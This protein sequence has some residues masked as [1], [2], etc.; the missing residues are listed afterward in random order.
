MLSPNQ[1]CDLI[2]ETNLMNKLPTNCSN[3]SSTLVSSIESRTPTSSYLI[4]KQSSALTTPTIQSVTPQFLN[5]FRQIP[6]SPISFKADSELLGQLSGDEL[7]YRI[8]S[9]EAKNRKLLFENGCLIK[10]IN[11]NLA[12]IQLIRHQMLE[13]KKDNSELRDLCCYLD[14]ERTRA[15]EIARE[16]ELFGDHISKVLKKEITNYNKKL[17]QLESKQFELVK[18]NYELK[19]LCLLLDK[20][21]MNKTN[22]KHQDDRSDLTDEYKSS[23][24]ESKRRPFVNQKILNYIKLLESELEQSE[25]NRQEL[26]NELKSSNDQKLSNDELNNKFSCTSKVK[27]LKDSRPDE[28]NKAFEIL[29]IEQSLD[30]ENLQTNSNE[31][32]NEDKSNEVVNDSND[33]ISE[34]QRVIIKQLCSAAYDKM[35]F[36]EEDDQ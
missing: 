33:M 21:T 27:E 11:S 28:L 20:A 23:T 9:L 34:D 1:S 10:D 29:S 32:N 18:E 31:I 8:K 16:W 26:I 4:D 13:L 24:S 6:I 17:Q 14:D 2:K 22:D 7:V 3:N 25:E 30:D 19:Q 35:I 36:D 5:Q 15:K 12:N